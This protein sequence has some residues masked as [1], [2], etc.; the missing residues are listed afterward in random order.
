MVMTGVQTLNNFY[1]TMMKLLLSV[2]LLKVI[3]CFLCLFINLFFFLIK[4]IFK[5]VQQTGFSTYIFQLNYQ[6]YRKLF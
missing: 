6:I 1:I 2:L 4:Q 5:T 3:S